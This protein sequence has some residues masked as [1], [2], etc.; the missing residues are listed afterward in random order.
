MVQDVLNTTNRPALALQGMLTIM[1]MTLNHAQIQLID[2]GDD[3]SITTSASVTIPVRWTGLAIPSGIVCANL[4]CIIAITFLCQLRTCFSK[5]GH[6]WHTAS[7]LILDK[8][9]NILQASP[10]SRDDHVAKEV[11]K[12]DPLVIINKCKRTGRVQVLQKDGFEKENNP[13]TL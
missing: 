11:P 1:A 4:I 9:V 6:F 8:T 2:I 3:V 13:T 12:G 7:Q 10:K 5:Q